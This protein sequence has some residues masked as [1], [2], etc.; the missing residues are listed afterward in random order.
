MLTPAQEVFDNNHRVVSQRGSAS[1][2][3]TFTAHEAGDHKICFV[4]SSTS[5]RSAWLSA[6]TPNGGIRM[7][8][9]LVIGETGQIESSDKDK[10]QD[11]AS[12][13]K[14]LNARLHDI[15]REQVFQRV[16]FFFSSSLV[17]LKLSMQPLQIIP[18]SLPQSDH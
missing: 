12:R 6:H 14:D 4:P 13:V 17:L 18:R 5:G 2:R 3:F 16:R 10:L 15:R 1:G 11:I 8:L 9:D 7:K